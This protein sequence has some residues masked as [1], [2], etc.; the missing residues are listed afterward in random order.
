MKKNQSGMVYEERYNADEMNSIKMKNDLEMI[1]KT[2]NDHNQIL[3]ELAKSSETLK[4]VQCE[5]DIDEELEV[6]NYYSGRINDL[7]DKNDAMVGRA[8]HRLE[9]MLENYS[10]SSLMCT[11]FILLLVLIVLLAI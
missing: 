7:T 9:N 3:D 6:H 8:M 5:E 10:S 11:I 2:K 1:E 4:N